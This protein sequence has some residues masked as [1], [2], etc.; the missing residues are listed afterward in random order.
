MVNTTESEVIFQ[1]H[2]A[3]N[4]AGL[5]YSGDIVPDGALHRIKANGDRS[6]NAWY[7]LHAD[8]VAAGVFGCWKRGITE[9]WCAKDTAELTQEERADRDRKWA[10]AKTQR[11]IE[12][13]RQQ[14]QAQAQGEAILAAAQP[15]LDDHPYHM[16]KGIRACPGVMVGNWPQRQQ[17]NT[18]LIPLRSADRLHPTPRPVATARCCEKWGE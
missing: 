2:Q 12:E 4:T 7:V 3:V 11:Q 17:D 16:W 18:L 10:E 9:T 5:D 14:E 6:P 15:A 8:E 1:F 13:C